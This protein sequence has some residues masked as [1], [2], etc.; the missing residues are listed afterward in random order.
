[1][2]FGTGGEAGQ[3]NPTTFSLSEAQSLNK[4]NEDFLAIITTKD[5]TRIF[6]KKLSDGCRK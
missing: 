5:S 6:D 1:V 3:L 2:V 4:T